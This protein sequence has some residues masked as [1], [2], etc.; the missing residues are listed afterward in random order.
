MTKTIAFVELPL[1]SG[2]MPL[3]SGY[4]EAM[5]RKDPD[6]R[7][8][9]VREDLP[10]RQ[11]AVR[12]A[13]LA[14]R[15]ARGRRLCVLVLRLELRS[16][17]SVGRR[18][19][20]RPATGA[21]HPRGP[22]GHAPGCALRAAAARQS[23]RVQRRRRADICRLRPRAALAGARF[24]RRSRFEL[25]PRSRARDHGA[26]AADQ[27]P[28]GDTVA[29]SRGR[30]RAPRV[31]LGGVDEVRISTVSPLLSWC[32]RGTIFPFAFAPTQRSPISVWMA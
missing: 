8:A 14:A 24:R 25:L 16:R 10:A 27:R 2:V 29:L 15:G 20:R 22:A 7:E 1:F 13:V 32:F 3:A 18:A 28:V 23:V 26:G 21:H 30:V 5:C 17:S 12:G 6:I 4:M 9:S 11:D 31:H 19:P